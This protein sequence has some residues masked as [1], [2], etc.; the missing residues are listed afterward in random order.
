MYSL[1]GGAYRVQDIRDRI[2]SLARPASLFLSLS[3]TNP[4]SLSLSLF[5][6]LFLFLAILLG[7]QTECRTFEI[8]YELLMGF[9]TCSK[10]R[11]QLDCIRGKDVRALIFRQECFRVPGLR[12]VLML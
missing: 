3:H 5:F 2:L 12:F 1:V 7:A 9:V 6:S 11:N 10:S 4:F 8:A